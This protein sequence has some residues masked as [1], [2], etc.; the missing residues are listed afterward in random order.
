M[1][2]IVCVVFF[3]LCFL[4]SCLAQETVEYCCTY[5][6][7]NG[8][9]KKWSKPTFIIITF[10]N[11]YAGFYYSDEYGNCTG[12][13]SDNSRRIYKYQRTESDYHVYAP[14]FHSA[15]PVGTKEYH[16]DVALY[17]TFYCEEK[18]SKDFS[19]WNKPLPNTRTIFIYKRVSKAEKEA[20]L[21]EYEDSL[22]TL[23]R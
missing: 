12:Y 21:R 11:D 22:P 9:K 19:V 3:L 1:K 16:L 10:I 8:V 23:L 7:E 13:N 6:Y 4:G 20:I 17:K 15:A 2:K 5:Y 14:E 18:F